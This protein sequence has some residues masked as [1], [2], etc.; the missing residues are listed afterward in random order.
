M[1][2]ANKQD[3]KEV[4]T[5]LAAGGLSEVLLAQ[6]ED[7]EGQ[8]PGAEC[9]S[10]SGGPGGSGFRRGAVVQRARSHS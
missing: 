7:G 6:P 9:P 3:G 5:A 1:A 10:Y 8:G 4:F 2:E